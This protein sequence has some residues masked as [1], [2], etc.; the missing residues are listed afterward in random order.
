M[1]EEEQVCKKPCDPDIGCEECASYWQQMVAEG[2]WDGLN[3]H[4]TD[5]GW[6]EML[7]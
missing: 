3:H 5:K 2:F 1:D 4:W 7:K 6:R